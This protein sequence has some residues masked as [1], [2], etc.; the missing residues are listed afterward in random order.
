[1]KGTFSKRVECK[2]ANKVSKKHTKKEFLISNLQGIRAFSSEPN[3]TQIFLATLIVAQIV[4]KSPAF[5]RIGKF[6]TAN[7]NFGQNYN[8]YIYIYNIVVHNFIF[9]RL[10]WVIIRLNASA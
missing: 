6:I 7:T 10:Y 1:M 2:L 3:E 4:N 8:L 9:I 5:Y